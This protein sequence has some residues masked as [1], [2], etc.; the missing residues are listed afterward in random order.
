MDL[1]LK[2]DTF[3]KYLLKK[4]LSDNTIKTYIETAKYLLCKKEIICRTKGT[5]IVYIAVQKHLIEIGLMRKEKVEKMN[6]KD[7]R[8][9]YIYS[10]LPNADQLEEIL[11]NVKDKHRLAFELSIHTGLRISE[12]CNLTS[13]DIIKNGSD[14]EIIVHSGK[15]NKFRKCLVIN[16]NEYLIRQLNNFNGINVKDTAIRSYV[17]NLAKKLKIKFSFHSLRHYFATALA[18]QGVDIITLSKVLGHSKLDT[19][20]V[21]VNLCFEDVKNK[22]KQ[23]DIKI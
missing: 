7:N 5:N 23:Y 21:Y 6:K 2:L 11:K 15:G 17:Y 16:P 10:K 22:I 1:T 20:K 8:E 4:G 13:H 19:T 14:Y 9:N 12:V 18:T 3:K